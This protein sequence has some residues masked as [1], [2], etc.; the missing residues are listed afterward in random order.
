MADVDRR[1]DEELNRLNQLEESLRDPQGCVA[2]PNSDLS[3]DV[4]RLP[5]IWATSVVH[6]SLRHAIECL[7]A[8]GTLLSDGE[9][10]HAP[11]VLARGAYESSALA[12]W[13]LQPD[14]ADARLSRLIA[15]HG[16][17]WRYSE[18][19]YGGTTLDDDGF[20]SER[21]QYAAKM[22][23]IAGVNK[24]ECRFPGFERLIESVDDF[25]GQGES[26]LTAWRLCSGVSHAKTWA[27]NEITVEV[28]RL[29]ESEHLHFSARVPNRSLG[30]TFLGVGRRT[31]ER[32]SIV[33]SIRTSTRPHGIRMQMR[34]STAD[35]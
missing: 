34:R 33:L 11:F 13:L 28:D 8:A 30:V 1:L 17:S 15:Q 6:R 24:S 20:H 21:R 35:S 3:A 25:P 23:A 5:D 19:A 29:D 31:V 27:L 32:A 18:K 16:D 7:Y 10:L 2:R 9:W 12:V 14:S 22:S 4:A 26:L